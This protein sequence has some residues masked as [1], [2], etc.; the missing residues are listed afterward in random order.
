MEL[1]E[2]K[3]KILAEMGL[4]ELIKLRE[5]V[6]KEIKWAREEAEVLGVHN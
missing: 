5:L 2:I 4:D 3:E 1:E 6:N